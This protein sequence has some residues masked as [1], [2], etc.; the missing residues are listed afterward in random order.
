MAVL[1]NL[2][3]L[4]YNEPIYSFKICIFKPKLRFFVQILMK[5][6][7]HFT[8]MLRMS[9]IFN[10][11]KKKKNPIFGKIREKFGN[12][13]IIQKIIQNYSVV[14]LAVFNVR[15]PRGARPRTAA[16]TRRGRPRRPSAPSRTG[17]W[18]H[19]MKL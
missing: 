1:N 5:F 9:R 17:T 14:S 18:T 13:P 4:F 7:R 11:L 10:F 8:N 19:E 3:K 16:G 6:C 15:T 2:N 12:V